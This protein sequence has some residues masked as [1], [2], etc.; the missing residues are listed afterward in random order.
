MSDITRL[1]KRWTDGDENAFGELMP[2]VYAE[3]R[4]LARH[5]MRQER[6]NHTL[7]PT[8]LVHEAFLRLNAHESGFADRVHFYAA[9]AHAMRRVLVDHAREQQ[10]LKRGG[11]MRPVTLDDDA[12]G[13]VD[14]RFDLLA[15]HDALDRLAQIAPEKATVVE[16]RYFGGMSVEE[17][18]EYLGISPATVKRHWS[19]A[20]AW[21]FRA[22]TGG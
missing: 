2:I 3:L 6:S 18:A 16:L 17:T 1:L 12:V 19:F 13:A 5:H 10:A 21:L 14:L 7:Q 9:A 4:K 20:R 15:L 11:A 22:L 8:A